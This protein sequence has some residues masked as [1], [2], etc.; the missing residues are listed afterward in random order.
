MKSSRTRLS[1][2]IN[3]FSQID[4]LRLDLL[5]QI[6]N[7]TLDGINVDDSVEEERQADILV[8]KLEF[9]NSIAENIIVGFMENGELNGN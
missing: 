9:V 7:L 8:N 1:E 4:E 5:T 3:L 2:Y 6:T